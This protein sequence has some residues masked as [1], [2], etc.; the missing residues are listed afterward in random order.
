VVTQ[1][2]QLEWQPSWAPVIGTVVV[3]AAVTVLLGL[4]GSWRA[5]SVRPNVV[6]RG[7]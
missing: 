2:F 3:G 7:L 4:V 5:L 6:L 1:L